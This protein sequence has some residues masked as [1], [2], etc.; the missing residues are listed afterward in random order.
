[1]IKTPPREKYHRILAAAIKV[2]SANGLEK[3]KISDIV[4]EAGV[5]QGT[6]YL[7][8]SSKNAL[9]PAIASELLEKLLL[10][11]KQKTHCNLS[12]WDALHTVIEVTFNVTKSYQNVLVLCYSGFAL[13]CSFE[14]WE[15]TY[16]PY[17]EWFEEQ[18]YNAQQRG[19]ILPH[20]NVKRTVSMIINLIEDSAER[21]YLFRA[22][23]GSIEDIKRDLFLFIKNALTK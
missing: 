10:E 5:A 11:I 22:Q 16:N 3:T 17:Y 21:L 6:F 12:F 18:V 14:I 4:K 23:E 20:H 9:I 13:N 15:K 7:Y 19:E 1:M 8:F 2:I